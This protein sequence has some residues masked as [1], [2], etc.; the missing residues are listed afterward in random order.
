MN[1]RNISAVLVIGVGAA[2]VHLEARVSM[3][4]KFGYGGQLPTQTLDVPGA[5]EPDTGFTI[6]IRNDDFEMSSRGGARVVVYGHDGSQIYGDLITIDDSTVSVYAYSD[7][8]YSAK[9]PF[10]SGIN[11][12]RLDE[13]DKIVV[14]GRGH[15]LE[16]MVIGVLGGMLTGSLLTRVMDKELP[17]ALAAGPAVLGGAGLVSGA[18]IGYWMSSSDM[19]ISMFSPGQRAILRSLSR[20]SVSPS[21]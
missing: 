19:E 16:G 21:R 7:F 18:A 2:V 14:K 15:M 6:S 17:S 1:W 4:A 10:I 12:F 5:G 9:W 20:A 8:S 13:I 11:T 3:T